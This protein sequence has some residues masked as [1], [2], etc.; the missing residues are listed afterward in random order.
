MAILTD[1]ERLQ[2]RAVF[3]QLN[4]AER[5]AIGITK[6]DLAAAAAA[7]DSFFDTNAA[8]INQAIPQPARAALTTRQKAILVTA[9]IRKRYGA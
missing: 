9:V 4:N 6:A 8:A 5:N 1:E 3:N 2:V 7:I